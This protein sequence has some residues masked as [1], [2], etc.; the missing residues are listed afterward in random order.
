MILAQELPGEDITERAE[1]GDA[2]AQYLVGQSYKKSQN[3]LLA[4]DWLSRSAKQGYTQ[5]QYE[6]GKMYDQG[7]GIPENNRLAAEWYLSAAEAGLASAQ[8]RL[9]EMYSSGKADSADSNDDSTM[10]H[11]SDC[12]D[13]NRNSLQ[14]SCGF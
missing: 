11:S 4:V 5:A 8:Y 9:S 3:N 12:T 13:D 1:S 2:E 6:L 14:C 10:G 7:L